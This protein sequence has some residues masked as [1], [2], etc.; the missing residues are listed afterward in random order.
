MLY[1]VGFSLPYSHIA[2]FCRL[3]ADVL[4][5][6]SASPAYVAKPLFKIMI[7]LSCILPSSGWFSSALL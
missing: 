7:Q 3:L 5:P 6:F 2:S 1:L 4:Q